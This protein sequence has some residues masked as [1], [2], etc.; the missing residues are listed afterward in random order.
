MISWLLIGSMPLPGSTAP[1]N[2]PSLVQSFTDLAKHAL[3]G[4]LLPKLEENTAAA[5]VT[6]KVSQDHRQC[7]IPF[8]F[9]HLHHFQDITTCD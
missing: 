8:S 5:E 4:V 6:V 7:M 2:S 9:F 3:E 1:T